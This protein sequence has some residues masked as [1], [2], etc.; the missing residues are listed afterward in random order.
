MKRRTIVGIAFV[1]VA[2]LKLATMWDIL[3]LDWLWNH[4]WTAYLGPL[5]L[6]Y[7]GAELIIYS[8]SHDRRQWLHRPL[9]IGDDGKRICC[10]VHYGADEY[11]FRGEPFH[12]AR[13]DAFCGGIRLDLRKALITEDEEI[14]IHTFLGGVEILVS[15]D[16]NVEVKSRSFLGGT[17]NETDNE[18]TN[19]GP[20]LHIIASNFLGGVDIKN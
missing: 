17:G 19:S 14:D 13:L 1:V 11:T 15:K 4:P 5:L 16:I 10:S 6:L 9:P 7:I 3:E 20:C 12:G 18:T 8:Y 2:L